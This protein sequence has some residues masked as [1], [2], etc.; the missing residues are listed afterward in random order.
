MHKLKFSCQIMKKDVSI[1]NEFN[2]IIFDEKCKWKRE[3]V[4]RCHEKFDEEEVF[5]V[6]RTVFR[7][8]VKSGEV[9][10]KLSFETWKCFS[11]E[12]FGLWMKIFLNRC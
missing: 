10:E 5:Q 9:I 6:W 7:V 12:N 2:F 3:W 4:C 11:L 8:E 1:Q